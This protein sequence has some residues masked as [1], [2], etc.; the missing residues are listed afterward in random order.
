MNAPLAKE[1]IAL[2]MS[3]SLT[4]R[5][6]V[7][8]GT[9]GT[10]VT[11]QPSGRGLMARMRAAIAHLKELPRRRAVLDELSLLTDR[12][13]ADLGLNRGELGRVFDPAFAK[14]RQGSIYG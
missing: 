9:D 13:L 11:P 12:E 1:Q 14:A 4:Y 6:P 8:Q 3:D 2:L 7:V 5:T 10:L